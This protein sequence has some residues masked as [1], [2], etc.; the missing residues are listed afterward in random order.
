MRLRTVTSLAAFGARVPTIARAQ[1]ESPITK[2]AREVVALINGATP[3]KLS[4]FVDSA[5]DDGM[6]RLPMRAHVDFF[7]SQHD[8]AGGLEWVEV[9]NEQPGETVALLKRKLTGDYVALA[10]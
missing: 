1:T 8:Q 5:F 3:A 4:A 7:M 6:R 10:I 2:R 9:Q